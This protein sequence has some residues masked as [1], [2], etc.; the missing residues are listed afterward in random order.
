MSDRADALIA[1]TKAIR[2]AETGHSLVALTKTINGVGEAFQV[3]KDAN[4]ARVAELKQKIAALESNGGAS[5]EQIAQLLERVEELEARNASPGKVGN[6][7]AQRRYTVHNLGDEKVYELPADVKMADVIRPAKEPPISLERWLAAAMLGEKCRDREAVQYARELKALTTGSTGVLVPEEF[8]SQWIDNLR[9]RMVLNAAGMTTVTMQQQTQTHSRVL[10][11]PSV[12]WHAEAAAISA[13]D[14]TFE[15]RQL[16][17]KTAVARVQG[18]VELAQDSPDFGSQLLGV[19]ARALAAEYD[20]VGL[21]GAGSATEPRGIINTTGINSVTGG[22]ITNY[23]FF[24]DAIAELWIDNVPE[25]RVGPFA[26]SPQ[27]LKKL[28]KL[29]TGIASDQTPL[30]PPPG[31][32]RFLVTSQLNDGGSPATSKAVVGDWADLVLGVRREVSLESLRVTTYVSNL[33]IEFLAYGRID[34]LVRR[35]VSFTKITGLVN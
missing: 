35:P 9:A 13:S 1:Q 15:L 7:K 14:P 18:S 28:R 29:K 20:R 27:T 34:Y 10:T 4:D 32:P 17:A 31:L 23:D 16:V 12:T 8:I 21:E 11:D 6:G 33:Q 26:V 22:A 25:D 30:P 5:P 24:L 3:F 19:M 2:A